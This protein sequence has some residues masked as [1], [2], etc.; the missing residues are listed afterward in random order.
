MANR[1]SKRQGFTLVELLV[2]IAIIAIL[3]ALLLPA[4]N[5][6]REAARRNSCINN[7]RQWGLAI[8]NH[9]STTRKYPLATDSY[10]QVVATGVKTWASYKD[11]AASGSIVRAFPGALGSGTT[12]PATAPVP[13]GYSWAVRCL[14]YA[15][16]TALAQQVSKFRYI[17][18]SAFNSVVTATPMLGVQVAGS[19]VL[20]GHVSSAS[21]ASLICPSYAGNEEVGYA[22]TGVPNATTSKPKVGNY[23]AMVGTHFQA[24]PAPAGVIENGALVSGAQNQGKSTGI[25]DVRDGTSKTVVLAESKEEYYGSWYDGQTSWVTALPRMP[26]VVLNTTTPLDGEGYPVFTTPPNPVTAMNYGPKA[27]ATDTDRQRY[28]ASGS[29]AINPAPVPYNNT[30]QA[31]REWGPSSEHSGGVIVHVFADNHVVAI[32]DSTDAKVYFSVVTRAGSE[33]GKGVE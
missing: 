30:A 3:V 8:L 17:P 15:E 11:A 10:A 33:S 7:C 27:N 31:F 23:C 21:I 22:Y 28:W 6:A 2:V 18:G 5:A 13:A 19:T 9:E 29:G 26:V 14:A 20:P 12:A 24:T 16:E 32:P 4:V 1:F 25:N